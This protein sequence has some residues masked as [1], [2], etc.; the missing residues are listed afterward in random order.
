M[1][2][3]ILVVVGAAGG[4]CAYRIGHTHGC[5]DTLKL[6]GTARVEEVFRQVE[7]DVA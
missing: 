2:Y 6:I 3:T 4:I 7:R 1:I 5:L